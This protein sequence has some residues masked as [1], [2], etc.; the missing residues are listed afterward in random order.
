MDTIELTRFSLTCILGVLDREQVT[1]QT[2]EVEVRLGV[3]LTASGEED[4]LDKTVD[5]AEVMEQ[6]TAIAGEGRWRLLESMSLA[7]CRLL[8]APPAPGEARAPIAMVDLM[9][10]KPEILGGRAVP[11]IRMVRYAGLPIEDREFGT[12]VRADVLAETPR[13][14]AYRLHLAPGAMFEGSTAWSYRRIAGEVAFQ[15]VLVRNTGSEPASVLAI[16]R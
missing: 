5:Y 2:L 8:L 3:D 1:P 15:D 6:I 7:I 13:T 4:R 14:S 16:R 11:G 9:L 12:G 10:R